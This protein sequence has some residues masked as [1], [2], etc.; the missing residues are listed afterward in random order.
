M[1]LL[2][3]R[4][5]REAKDAAIMRL[6]LEA[7][8]LPDPAVP[9]F[10]AETIARGPEWTTAALSA[11]HNIVLLRPTDRCR[12]YNDRRRATVPVPPH[13][14]RAFC[15]CCKGQRLFVSSRPSPR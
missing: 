3:R 1:L 6:L 12:H 5:R 15:G 2:T 10:L 8:W 7:P 4:Q 13:T 11:A 9:S 14:L